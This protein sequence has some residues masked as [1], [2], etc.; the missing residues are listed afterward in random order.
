LETQIR[1]LS[2]LRP[3]QKVHKTP[4]S[5]KLDVVVHNSY[6][7][8]INRRIMVQGNPCL[9]ARPYPNNNDNSNK[10]KRTG[11]MVPVLSFCLARARF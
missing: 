8:D 3:A 5:T 7:G 9:N 1:V 11:R 4:I 10:V 6:V 2:G